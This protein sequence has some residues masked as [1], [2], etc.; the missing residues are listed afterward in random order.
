MPDP[1]L[2][3]RGMTS[4]I[5]IDATRQF[6]EEGGPESWPP[7]S[8]ELLEEG[9]PNLFNEVDENWDDYLKNWP[10]SDS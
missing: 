7:V 2:P 9:A 3:K 5:V 8:R 1:S 6:P 10:S 4:K